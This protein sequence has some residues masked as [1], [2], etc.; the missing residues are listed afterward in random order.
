MFLDFTDVNRG[1][2]EANPSPFVEWFYEQIR[3]RD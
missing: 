3:I 1:V 2:H